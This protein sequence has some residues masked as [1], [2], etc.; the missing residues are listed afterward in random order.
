MQSSLGKGDRAAIGAG[1]LVSI[2]FYTN[3]GLPRQSS[4]EEG[5]AALRGPGCPFSRR[6]AEI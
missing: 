3:A 1:V 2:V 5:R 4:I 6:G